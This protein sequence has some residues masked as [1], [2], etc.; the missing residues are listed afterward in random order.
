ML[1]LEGTL[2]IRGIPIIFLLIVVVAVITCSLRV[3][4]IQQQVLELLMR[5][6]EVIEECLELPS[7]FLQTVDRL[8]IGQLKADQNEEAPDKR[9]Q[10]RINDINDPENFEHRFWQTFERSRPPKSA[11][12]TSSMQLR[13]F[14]LTL[15]PSS[16]PRTCAKASSKASIAFSSTLVHESYTRDSR[17]RGLRLQ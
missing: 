1:L 10:V 8:Q 2:F 15:T 14:S 7:I 3:I 4:L 16:I 13:V 17:S 6:R 12:T 9:M 5:S 11:A